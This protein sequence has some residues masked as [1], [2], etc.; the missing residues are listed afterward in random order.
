LTST[1]SHFERFGRQ[2]SS[3]PSGG[4]PA[5]PAAA[6]RTIEVDKKRT[7]SAEPIDQR[8]RGAVLDHVKGSRLRRRF[9]R[10]T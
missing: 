8:Q 4:W 3:S 5:A 9:A 10:L 2:R 1:E 7:E 6:A